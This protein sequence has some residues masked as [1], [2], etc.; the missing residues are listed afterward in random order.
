MSV[1]S[2]EACRAYGRGASSVTVMNMIAALW[3]FAEATVFF[4]VPDVFLSA[5]GLRRL[6]IGLVAC[7][8]ALAGA[9]IGGVVMYEWALRDARGSFAVVEAVPAVSSEMLER[10]HRSLAEKGVSA[11]LAGP[12]F[13]IPYKAYAIQAAAIGIGLG[14]FLLVSIPARLFRFLAVT[15]LCGWIGDRLM[16]AWTFRR[17]LAILLTCW[18]VFYAFYLT[19]MPN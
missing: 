13:G 18:V 9:L 3:G 16:S 15:L 19:V 11:I 4:I 2:Y 7:L 10:V 17:K 12:L 5:L 8:F 1:N 6:R 14:S